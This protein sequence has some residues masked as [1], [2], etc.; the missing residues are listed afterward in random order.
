MFIVTS[1]YYSSSLSVWMFN[2]FR[3]KYTSF[4]THII[5]CTIHKMTFR[6]SLFMRRCALLI[7]TTIQS[8]LDKILMQIKSNTKKAKMPLL[9]TYGYDNPPIILCTNW[10]E[11]ELGIFNLSLSHCRIHPYL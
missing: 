3:H 6:T 11:L 2:S 10:N 8:H 9:Y 4:N 5:L 1:L 7:C